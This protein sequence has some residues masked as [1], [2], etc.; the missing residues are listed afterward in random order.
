MD[1]ET[2]VSACEEEGYRVVFTPLENHAGAYV[3]D[4]NTIFINQCLTGV[5]QVCALLHE[6]YHARNGHDGHQSPK[7]ESE[8]DLTAAR[9]L[10]SL[11][12]FLLAVQ[13]YPDNVFAVAEHLNVTPDLVRVFRED[14]TR[15]GGTL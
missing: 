12:E 15:K 3:K 9:Q 8:A 2:L 7:I 6:L 10:I 5:E 4:V 14:L 11:P 1:I 13:L